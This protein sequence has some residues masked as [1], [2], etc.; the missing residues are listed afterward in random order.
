MN[1]ELRTKLLFLIDFQWS[2]N[3]HPMKLS[4]CTTWHFPFCKF[5]CW[6]PLKMT[7]E[8][9]K[10]IIKHQE[11]VYN[12]IVISIP[13]TELNWWVTYATG[14]SDTV[15]VL[16]T[17]I[18]ILCVFD[19]AETSI[20]GSNGN[21]TRTQTQM[22][23]SECERL[24]LA[25]SVNGPQ[26]FYIQGSST[27]ECQ[28]PRSPSLDERHKNTFPSIFHSIFKDDLI[29]NCHPWQHVYFYHVPN[30]LLMRVI[31]WSADG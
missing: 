5:L 18:P 19:S 14:I 24:T 30:P 22:M 26:R 1:K 3:K 27:H 23:G 17:V 20:D 6:T 9:I 16:W 29:R 8:K 28:S 10:K 21:K 25:L 15:S 4:A 12:I 13:Y 2:S 11:K 31:C 7:F